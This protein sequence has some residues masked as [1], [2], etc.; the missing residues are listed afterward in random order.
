MT[1]PCLL[2]ALFLAGATRLAAEDRFSWLNAREQQRLAPA[3]IDGHELLDPSAARQSTAAAANVPL[4]YD[5]AYQLPDEPSG[6]ARRQEFRP[7]CDSDCLISSLDTW[8]DCEMPACTTDQW[9]C[10]PCECS[11]GNCYLTEDGCWVSNDSFCDVGDDSVIWTDTAARFGWWAVGT[12]GSPTQIGQ[13]QDLRSS[14][15]WDVDAIHSDGQRT[16]DLTLSGLDNEAN[17]AQGLYYGPDLTAKV[18]YN[19]FLRRWDH[20]PLYG[21]AQ[22]PTPLYGMNPPPGPNDNVV[23]QDLNVGE[24]YAIR[25][26]MLDARFQGNLSENVKWRLNL[27][28]QRKFGERQANA[29]AHCFNVLDVPGNGPGQNIPAGANGNVCHVLSQ[30]Q[31]IDWL[32]MEIQPVVEA[33]FDNV[34]LEYSHT[35]RSFGQNDQ[36]VGT[37]YTRFNF[38]S[39]S[40]SGFLGP[41][42]DYALVPENVTQIDRVKA[43]VTLSETSSIYANLYVGDTQNQFRDTH[44]QFGGYDIRWIDR[45]LERVTST[46]YVSNYD[47]NNEIPPFFLNAP[48]LSPANNYDQNS[49]R[50]P[51]DYSRSRAGWRGN[52]RPTRDYTNGFSLAGGYEYYQLARDYAQ[53]ETA[54]GTFVQPDTKSHNF[55]IAPQMRWSPTR[56]S[57]VRYKVALIEDPLIGVREHNGRFNTNQ[58]DQTHSIDIGGTWTP[59]DNFVATAQF[60]LFN[61]WHSSQFANFNE[62]N[63]PF[64]C[65]LFYAPTD[66]LSLT[67]GYAY[68]SN[69]INQDITL[70]FTVPN[71]PVP[72]LRTETTSWN[73]RGQNH[74]ININA[75]YAWTSWVN[76]MAGYEWNHGTNRFSLPA[77]P[78]G[79]DWTLLPVLSDVAVETQRATIGADFQPYRNLSLY[80]RYV[81]YDWN[82]IAANFDSG[83]ANMFLGGG[84]MTW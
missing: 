27:W 39:P 4:V 73:Y 50:H 16:L 61:S 47:E 71:V 57:Y 58:P 59:A 52:W 29:T 23:V 84:T 42:Y 79:A 78:A 70:G 32:T 13:F 21:L 19:R 65:T 6:A 81:L 28:G 60:T 49:I 80:A 45:S 5:V 53:Y 41:N 17:F 48:P 7:V 14:P 54:L 25:V 40:P 33:R 68:L 63:Y 38:N 22:S 2:I 26:E 10:N 9:F 83:T 72:P 56:T 11:H 3:V 12:S 46:F 36:V 24:D 44:R 82:D 20:D 18:K 66:R 55:D 8:C 34:T 51:V 62:D 64:N 67:G 43:N 76:V 69:W 75:N 30:K 15:F 74:L 77:S 31:N 1:R 35:T 37:Q